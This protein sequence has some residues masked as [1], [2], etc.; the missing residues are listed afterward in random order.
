[1]NAP[2]ST[3]SRRAIL[4]GALVVSFSL[5]ALPSLAQEEQ[6]AGVKPPLPG[7]LKK[8]PM[9]DSWI[10]IEADKTITVFT[11]KCEIGQGIK[12]ALVQVAAEELEVDPHAIHLV[13]SDTARTANEGY[14]SGSNSMKD[15]GTAIRNAAAQVRELLIAEAARRLDL[16][17]ENLRTEKGEV[18]APDGQR[19]RYGELVSGDMLHVQAQP[20]SK[21]KDPA[22]FKVM[23]QPIPRVDIPAK[24]TG[25]AAYVQDL[26]LPGMVHARVVRPPG[27]RARLTECDTT[28]VEKM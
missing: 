20:T 24:V 22:R 4:K 2:F 23:G 14:T 1:M 7:S 21:L 13:T 5:R 10:R 16:P 9:L 27:Y 25:G 19:L 6:N 26:R 18:I 8:A 17:T 12:T 3:P 28:A 11:G 15:S